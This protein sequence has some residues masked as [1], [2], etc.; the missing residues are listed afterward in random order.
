MHSITFL[1]DMMLSFRELTSSY[2]MALLNP[3]QK[4]VLQSVLAFIAGNQ[5]IH[6]YMNPLSDIGELTKEKKSRLWEQYLL[7]KHANNE[8][9]KGQSDR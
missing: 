1:K 4:T 8:S 7:N 3:H 9:L 2:R 6:F 5:V